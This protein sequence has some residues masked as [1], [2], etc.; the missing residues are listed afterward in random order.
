[1]TVVP[2]RVPKDAAQALKKARQP[3]W[4]EP[5]LATLTGALL[6]AYHPVR[7]GAHGK[8][9]HPRFLG[10]RTDKKARNVVREA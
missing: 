1:M 6:L 7:K 10:L 9:R 3:A 4:V 5:M 2:A 8:L